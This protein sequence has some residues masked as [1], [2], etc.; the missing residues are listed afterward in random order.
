MTDLLSRLLD[1][2]HRKVVFVASLGH[3]PVNVV[4]GG[5]LAAGGPRQRTLVRLSCLDGDA[6][7]D[8][9]DP[10]D[11][12]D[13]VVD[14]LDCAP[15]DPAVSSAPLVGATLGWPSKSTLSWTAVAGAATYNTY[16]GTIPPSGGIVYDLVYNPR[17]TR[18][19]RDAEAAGCRAIGGLEMLVA[20]AA[21]QFAWW[22]GLDAPTG[23]MREAATN[24]LEEMAGSE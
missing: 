10:D 22:T 4:G 16:R 17:R 2:V 8:A 11:D 24:R 12:N 18:L 5:D 15:F 23:V 7:G 9:C 6:Q 13:G 1:S 21:L 14:S 19:L 3:G 20:Q